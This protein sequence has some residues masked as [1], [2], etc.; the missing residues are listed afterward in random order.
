VEF[1]RPFGRRDCRRRREQRFGRFVAAKRFGRP[2]RA[3]A[4]PGRGHARRCARGRLHQHQPALLLLELQPSIGPSPGPR[5]QSLGGGA[6]AAT[7][8]PLFLLRGVGLG[9]T[10][11]MHAIGNAVM[12][13][14]PRKR[15][16]Y[17][18]SEKFTNEFITRQ[19][20]RARSTISE[21]A[22]AGSISPHRRH[23]VHRRQ[24]ADPGGVLR[25]RSMPSHEDGKQIVLVVGSA[26][27]G[28]PD[29]RGSASAVAFEWG[30]SSRT[31]TRADL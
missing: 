1:R 30:A 24:G 19:S 28:D 16:V 25:T 7:L 18:T 10:H 20:S 9:K 31:L 6:T 23:P 15:V 17:A 29:P 26:G 8:Q 2:C 22:T 4:R 3:A 27:Q 13:R 21:L 14:F 12:A 11:L 5:T